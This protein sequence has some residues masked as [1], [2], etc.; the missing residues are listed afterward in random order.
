MSVIVP[1]NRRDFVLRPSVSVVP[2]PPRAAAEPALA[3]AAREMG[4][5]LGAV[6]WSGGITLV[7]AAGVGLSVTVQARAD[8]AEQAERVVLLSPAASAASE[9]NEPARVAL[10]LRVPRAQ[11]VAAI[12]RYRDGRLV[13]VLAELRMNV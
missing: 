12:A 8:A 5:E 13:G 7:A 11:L 2:L 10:D 9:P 1:F 3:V 6:S 4:V